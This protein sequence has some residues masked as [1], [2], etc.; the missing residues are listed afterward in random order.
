MLTSCFLAFFCAIA[1]IYAAIG[2]GF[3]LFNG[4]FAEFF[5]PLE[6]SGII[7]LWGAR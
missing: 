3:Y 2:G 1:V 4:N 7:N 6:L 5:S